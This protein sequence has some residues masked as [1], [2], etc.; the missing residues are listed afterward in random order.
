L[1]I[2]GSTALDVTQ[3]SRAE[4]ERNCPKPAGDEQGAPV[5]LDVAGDGLRCALNTLRGFGAFGVQCLKLLRQGWQLT[6]NI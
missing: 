5:G 3:K 6:G 2:S 1:S 4:H